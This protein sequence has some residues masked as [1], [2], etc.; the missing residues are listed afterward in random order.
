MV[1]VLKHPG[2]HANDVCGRTI[3]GN[4]TGLEFELFGRRVDRVDFHSTL[5]EPEPNTVKVGGSTVDVLCGKYEAA[6]RD[7]IGGSAIIYCNGAFIC[8]VRKFK[9]T[10]IVARE[11]APAHQ[12]G[13]V[14]VVKLTKEDG[15]PKPRK[16]KLDFAFEQY[17]EFFVAV[18]GAAESYLD[19]LVRHNPLFRKYLDIIEELEVVMRKFNRK[20][21]DASIRG[22][23]VPHLFSD[24]EQQ[25]YDKLVPHPMSLNQMTEKVKQDVYPTHHEF[26]ADL[27]RVFNNAKAYH[28]VMR[29]TLR[30]YTIS[31]SDGAYT[32][33]AVMLHLK[34]QDDF[35]DRV[36]NMCRYRF[37]NKLLDEETKFQPG[38]VLELPGEG[39]VAL[40]KRIRRFLKE[41][42]NDYLPDIEK[43]AKSMKTL[44][45]TDT[46]AQ[47][48]KCKIWRRVGQA[49]DTKFKDDAFYCKFIERTCSVPHET[50]YQKDEDVDVISPPK[51][52]K[53]SREPSPPSKDSVTQ[54]FK[55]PKEKSKQAAQTRKLVKVAGLKGSLAESANGTYSFSTES[56]LVD[57]D[58]Y[59]HKEGWVL[60]E[61][62]LKKGAWKLS[63]K[64]FSEEHV[65]ANGKGKKLASFIEVSQLH[66][67]PCGTWFVAEQVSSP[68]I[69]TGEEQVL[70][71]T[72]V[73]PC[74]E[75]A[76]QYPTRGR[77][78]SITKLCGGGGGE[79]RRKKNVQVPDEIG[80]RRGLDR[81]PQLV[82]K[83]A[84]RL[85]IGA[86]LALDTK[87]YMLNGKVRC[88]ACTLK[89]NDYNHQVVWI[90][91]AAEHPKDARILFD[92][93]TKESGRAN[94]GDATPAIHH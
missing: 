89:R 88:D 52:F 48:T 70:Q 41:V 2:K 21:C 83:R 31:K 57:H 37:S 79:T 64:K 60:Y 81:N 80:P 34:I 9:V 28:S 26:V 72:D 54:P 24:T 45:G 50:D 25:E 65:A 82:M 87:Q 63:S 4:P 15:L 53:R 20:N 84:R 49:K 90:K 29:Y 67:L 7:N 94:S 92:D 78:G 47:C 61:R 32:I 13:A 38:N 75:E 73:S 58:C 27:L 68:G 23:L 30:K 56:D 14:I 40:M 33:P 85:N 17:E 44:A 22:V 10:E 18:K 69:L 77:S 36:L 91:F 12:H 42:N 35:K 39:D 8:W 86:E 74:T 16:T 51:G 19:R 11:G 5:V 1:V 55:R 3:D 6:K 66:T 59:K 62:K 46:L 93:L 71:I 43:T 76:H